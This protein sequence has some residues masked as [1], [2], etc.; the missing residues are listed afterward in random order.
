MIQ[1]SPFQPVWL[2]KNPHAQTLLANLI[3]PPYPEVHHETLTLPD[4]DSLEIARGTAQGESTVLILHGLEGSLKSAYAQRMMNFLNAHN[5][6]AVFMYFR[7]CNGKPNH[8]LRSYH[9]GET[10]DLKSVI[11]YLKQTGSKRIALVGYSL[12]GN[13]TLKYMGEAQTDDAVVCAVATSV[14]LQLDVCAARMNRGFSRIYQHDLMRRL[15]NKVVQKQPILLAAGIQQNPQPLKTF[16]QFDDAYTAPTH[17][18]KNAQ[19]YYQRC[20]SKQFLKNIDKPTLI[21]HSKDDPFMTREVIPSD[22]EISPQ[23]T[24]ELSE[25]GGHVGFI[26]GQTFKPQYWLE[27]RIMAFIEPCLALPQQKSE[28]AFK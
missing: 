19:D 27:P 16:V 21:I 10:D 28:P 25:H 6:P 4:G 7:G 23:V 2:L 22:D 1:K 18:F 14:P 5:I 12:G 26:G 20:S 3:H 8:S 9:S 17:G 11:E 15:K 24:L 13:V